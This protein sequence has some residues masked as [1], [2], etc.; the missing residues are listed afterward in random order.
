LNGLAVN[1]SGSQPLIYATTEDG[2][3]LIEITD[4]GSGTTSGATVLD[5][6]SANE[7]FRGLEFAP[8]PEPASCA[9]AGLGIAALF[10]FRKRNRS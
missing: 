1:F 5:T 4:A 7:A 10:V 9:L 3:S 8:V 6:A 2:T